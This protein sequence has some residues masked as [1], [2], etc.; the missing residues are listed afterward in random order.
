LR[1]RSRSWSTDRFAL[2]AITKSNIV[3]PNVQR[4]SPRLVGESMA[5][6]KAKMG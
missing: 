5:E 3:A 2:H 4:P 1:G 6:S